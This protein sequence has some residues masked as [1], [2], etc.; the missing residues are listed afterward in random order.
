MGERLDN[1][2]FHLGRSLR[3]LGTVERAS[4]GKPSSFGSAGTAPSE[5]KRLSV[6]DEGASAIERMGDGRFRCRG[7]IFNSEEQARQYARRASPVAPVLPTASVPPRYSPPPAVAS[8]PRLSA[9]ELSLMERHGIEV[10]P[11]GGFRAHGFVFRSLDQAVSWARR[12]AS[13]APSPDR[14]RPRAPSTH[15]AAPTQPARVP[16][17]PAPV[18]PQPAPVRPPPP[19][20]AMAVAP[21]RISR[22]GKPRWI[23]T[24]E[25]IQIGDVTLTT[26]LV[27]VGTGD[28]Y[29]Y[30]GNNAL[31][32]PKLSVG[33]SGDPEGLTL[34]YWS[35]YAHLDP[36]ARR[37]YLE[38]LA[39]GRSDPATPIGYIFLFFYGLERRLLHDNSRAEAERI[40]GEVRRLLQIHGDNHSFRSYAEKLL[41]IG[42][43][44][45]DSA[46]EPLSPSLDYSRHWEL[47][48]RLRV[49]LGRKLA[50]GEPLDADDALLWVLALPDTYLR[51]PA[52]RCFDEL[53]ELWSLRFQAAHP[54]GPTLRMPK[55]RIRH[56]YRAASGNFTADISID[57]LPDIAAISGPVRRWRELLDSCTQQLD[58]LS[59]LLG[60]RPEARGTLAAAAAAPADL[61]SGSAGEGLRACADA[62]RRLAGGDGL[63][64]VPV[65]ELLLLLDLEVPEGGGRIPVSTIRQMASLL[66]VLDTGYEPDRRYG[67]SV[68]PTAASRVVIFPAEGGGRVEHDRPEYA[69]A[70]TMVEIAA[71]AAVSDGV[72]VPVELESIRK[73]LL[74]L[75][76]LDPLERTRLIAHAEVLLEDPPKRKEAVS[77]LTSLPETHRRRI[78]QSAVSAVLADGRVLP[79]EVRFLEGLHSALGLPPE[80]VYSALHRAAVRDDEPVVVAEEERLPG[81]PLPRTAKEGDAVIALDDARLARIRGETLAVSE[82]LAEIFVDEEVPASPHPSRD[83]AVAA[84]RFEGLDEAHG[85]L[86]WVVVQEPL[87]WEA[88]DQHARG[89]RLLPAGAVET[90]NEW[91]F[92]IF[93]EPVLE[94]DDPISVYEHLVERLVEMGVRS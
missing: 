50:A 37:T 73:D 12:R 19:Q 27:Y 43:L 61:R 90:I 48:L 23:A 20:P 26:D 45:L 66:D 83:A 35:N 60:K 47:P 29:D 6:G 72:V 15:S 31:I 65:A 36:R 28:R 11:E 8:Q 39:A 41:E 46:G 4:A 17:A 84:C 63:A 49:Q 85:E 21:P 2:M 24:P 77:R 64:S 78:T 80:N 22:H 87:G 67:C 10:A 34:S 9:A 3:R 13:P 1:W 92:E 68:A 7:Y 89:A 16:V 54:K 93:E 33:R 79:A 18:R 56:V 69:A 91:G 58:P 38:W 74:S 44:F 76:G 59:R 75:P 40:T 57:E 62:V 42:D 55:A 51:T 14:M 5:S 32:D 81:V 71:L 25:T 82:L 94:E 52:T 53:R 88:F 30:P 86:L 70:R